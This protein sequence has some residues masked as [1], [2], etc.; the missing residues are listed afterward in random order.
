MLFFSGLE[1]FGALRAVRSD[2][3]NKSTTTIGSLGGLDENFD[4]ENW[5]NTRRSCIDA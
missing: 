4:Q 5:I 1:T 3:I 2:F